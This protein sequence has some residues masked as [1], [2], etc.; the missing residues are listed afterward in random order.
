MP[1]PNTLR[2]L[3]CIGEAC[4]EGVPFFVEVLIYHGQHLLPLFVAPTAF[5]VFHVLVRPAGVDG[6]DTF[7]LPG[8]YTE[9]RETA[10]HAFRTPTASAVFDVLARRST[11]QGKG[12]AV[13]DA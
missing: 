9:T 8:A 11:V 13:L 6:G 3:Q 7:F 5:V 4:H 1:S 10:F 12:F 2:G